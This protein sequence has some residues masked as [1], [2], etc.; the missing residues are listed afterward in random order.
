MVT[1]TY[2]ENISIS[3]CT[4]IIIKFEF[5][6]G[7]QSRENVSRKKHVLGVCLTLTIPEKRMSKRDEIS[8]VYIYNFVTLLTHNGSFLFPISSSVLSYQD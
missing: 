6:Y 5:S 7:I 8:Y 4:S 1:V 3:N 2:I